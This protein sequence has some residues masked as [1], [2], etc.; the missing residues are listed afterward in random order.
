[1]AVFITVSEQ[2]RAVPSMMV[3]DGRMLRTMEG[4]GELSPISAIQ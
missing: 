3:E 2:S 4:Q 1:M